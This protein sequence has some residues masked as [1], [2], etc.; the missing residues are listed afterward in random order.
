MNY[1]VK[2]NSG[3]ESV[4]VGLYNSSTGLLAQEGVYSRAVVWPGGTTE[5]PVDCVSGAL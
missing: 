2:A 4:P 3:M 5:V 1:A